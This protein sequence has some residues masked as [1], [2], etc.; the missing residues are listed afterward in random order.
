MAKNILLDLQ[1]YY[2][3]TEKN[4]AAEKLVLNELTSQKE[5]FDDNINNFY[6]SGIKKYWC[7]DVFEA[8]D[9][10]NFWF[11]FLDKDGELDQFNVKLVG[12]RTKTINDSLIKS[13]YFKETPEILFIFPLEEEIED[14][15]DA[16][17]PIYV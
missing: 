16:Y 17:M 4:L 12:V 5:S 2:R 1:E 7:K 11:D 9:M 13:I 3:T 8:P 15:K 10:L 6:D 14:Y